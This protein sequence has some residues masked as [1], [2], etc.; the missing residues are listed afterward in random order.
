V[1]S[2][3]AQ[4]VTQVGMLVFIVA[5]M[6]AMGLSLTIA[7]IVEP[8][9][10][11]RLV[12]GLL[13]A[14]FVVVPIV[15]VAAARLLPMEPDA[16]TAVILIGCA[17]GAPFLPKLAQLA[18][19]DPAF[20]VGA[21]VLLMVATIVYAPI[22]VPL[23]VEG[24]TVD[25]FGIA[26]S[27]VVLMLIPLGTG[28][29]IRARYSGLA[30]DWVGRTGQASS[31]GLLL[32]IGGSL[33]LAWRD[34]LGAIGTWIF[35]GAAVVLVAALVAGWLAAFGRSAGDRSVAALAT[36]QRNIAAAI[37]IAVSIGGDT[38]VYTLVGALVIPIVLIVLAGEVGRRVGHGEPEVAPTA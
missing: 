33:L 22:V 15:A 7:G 17:A 10:D 34:I 38:L 19:G 24:A 36:A 26:Q 1:L 32:G 25:A 21:M 8:L 2:D 5:G 23:A 35:V 18:K 6:A 31:I 37:V 9:R 29:L 27:L 3:T 12:G 16:G 11:L 14:N 28:L 20:A 4:V 30:D 13:V